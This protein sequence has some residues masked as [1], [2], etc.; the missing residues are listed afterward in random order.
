MDVQVWG[1]NMRAYVF[2]MAIRMYI[3]IESTNA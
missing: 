1:T 2:R 3:L